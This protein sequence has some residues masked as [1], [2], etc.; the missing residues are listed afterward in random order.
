[1]NEPSVRI[2]PHFDRV[3]YW[4]NIAQEFCLTNKSTSPSSFNQKLKQKEDFKANF[5][6]A[7]V[8]KI[9]VV[10]VHTTRSLTYMGREKKSSPNS[11]P[12]GQS[13]IHTIG[14]S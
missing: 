5:L 3:E 8:H 1:M 12:W 9:Y 14:P 7:I 4:A 6:E 11:V 13:T 2:V 10:V